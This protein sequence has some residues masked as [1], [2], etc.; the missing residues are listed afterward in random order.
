MNIGKGKAI[1]IG[2][3][4]LALFGLQT[5]SFVSSRN[6]MENQVL[7]LQQDIQS[8]R[9]ANDAR[10][11]DLTTGLQS[12]LQVVSEKI[13]V[14]SKDLVDAR[15]IAEQLKREQA[16]TAAGVRDELATH[17]QAV[18]ELRQEANQLA[19]GQNEA[20][21]RI[22]AV[23]GDVEGVKGDLNSTKTDLNSTK[24]D[25]AAS[26]KEMGD[27]RDSLGREIARN[28]SEVAQL[29]RLGER[30]YFEFNIP[31]A[32]NM[33]RVATSV[34]LQLKK[35]DPKTQKYDVSMLVDDNKMEKKGQLAREP[36]QFLVGRDRLRYELVVYNV[37]KDSIR[38]YVSVP[39]DATLSAE[40]PRLR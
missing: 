7:A 40:G 28:S 4:I 39:K 18:T 26:R 29:R 20:V 21:T 14:T 3:V 10:V 36:I 25:L 8:V 23:S 35:T 32:K 34:Q 31:K 30:D 22:G 15:R 37:D 17:S 33:E 9:A 27:I 2:A 1:A 5:W 24:T 11:A 19:E 12:D 16:K 6:N 38:G 13:G